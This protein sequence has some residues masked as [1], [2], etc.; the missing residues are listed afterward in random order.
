MIAEIRKHIKEAIKDCSGKYLEIDNP[1]FNERDLIQNKH[2]YQYALTFGPSNTIIND[3]GQGGVE[4]VPVNL[5]TFRQGDKD[6]L[7]IFDQGYTQAL[8][9][10]DLI[11]DR[12]LIAGREFIKGVTCTGVTPAGVQDS[13]D[14][15]S[16]EA[17]LIF[18]ISYSIGD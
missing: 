13:Q 18:T 2:D 3:D 10:R 16:Y 17:N 4:T 15:Y 9:I 11:L 8:T 12:T 14:I 1:F 7:S 6:K 5:K